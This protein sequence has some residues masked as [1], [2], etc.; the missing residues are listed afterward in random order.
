MINEIR[1]ELIILLDMQKAKKENSKEKEQFYLKW[2]LERY[3]VDIKN[4]LE[5][6]DRKKKELEDNLATLEYVREKLGVK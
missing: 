4:K 6:V 5:E 2:L 3:E 1:N